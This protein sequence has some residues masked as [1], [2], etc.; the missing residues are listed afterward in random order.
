MTRPLALA[1]LGV[2]LGIGPVNSQNPVV[3]PEGPPPVPREACVENGILVAKVVIVEYRTE[4]R[5]RTVKDPDGKETR[6]EYNVLVPV[7]RVVE[8]KVDPKKAVI[9]R[10]DGKT[11]SAGELAKVLE[12]PATV[13]MATN[14]E[15]VDPFYLQY[16]KPE[17]LIVVQER[18]VVAVPIGPRE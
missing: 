2:L 7:S 1:V 4:K 13:M 9:Y 5:T 10:A 12:K 15:K 11:V 17:T 16:L 14:Y 8:V 6:Q 3:R 18:P